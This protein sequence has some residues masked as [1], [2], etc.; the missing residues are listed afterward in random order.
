MG[1]SQ[2]WLR[3]ERTERQPRKARTSESLRLVSH[4]VLV[5]MVVCATG[6]SVAAQD[7][8]TGGGQATLVNLDFTERTVGGRLDAC[9]LVYLVAFKDYIYRNGG[10]VVLRGAINISALTGTKKAPGILLKV[11]PFDDA[12]GTPQLAPINYA[13]ITSDGQ[14]FAGSE[15]ATGKAEDGG[16]LVAFSLLDNMPLFAALTGGKFEINFNR[17]PNASDVKVPVNF[18]RD[19]PKV[20]ISFGNCMNKLLDVIR[21]KFEANR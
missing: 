1:I 15:L 6:R 3:S 7:Q 4:I 8:A 9:E 18:L 10:L 5:G 16:L 19:K 21:K 11:T 20:M 13:F 12:S 14:S 17:R 2:R